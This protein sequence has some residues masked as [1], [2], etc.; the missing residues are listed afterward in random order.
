MVRRQIPLFGAVMAILAGLALFLYERSSQR[1]E[2]G[3]MVILLI[4]A[5]IFWKKAQARPV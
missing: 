5:V 3:P 4:I 2:A 1:Q